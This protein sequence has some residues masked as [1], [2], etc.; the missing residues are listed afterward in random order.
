MPPATAADRRVR[1]DSPP[2]AL[3]STQRIDPVLRT[4]RID[5]AD[6]AD[7]IDPADPTER[8]DPAEAIDRIEPEDAADS[9]EANDAAESVDHELRIDFRLRSDQTAPRSSFIYRSL[10]GS[11]L[12]GRRPPMRS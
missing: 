12:P 2:T 1:S 5:P 6:P 7:K 11:T 10:V 9:T 8:I 3:L 4:E